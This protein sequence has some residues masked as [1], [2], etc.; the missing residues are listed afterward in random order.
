MLFI[1]EETGSIGWAGILVCYFFPVIVVVVYYFM[2]KSTFKNQDDLARRV[3]ILNLKNERT[4]SRMTEWLKAHPS[5]IKTA[6][7]WE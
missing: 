4:K 1:D 3:E 7:K 5:Y 2:M 6:R